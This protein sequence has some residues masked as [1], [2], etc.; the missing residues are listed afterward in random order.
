MTRKR[1]LRLMILH[2][3]QRRLRDA[4]TFMPASIL[5][6][7][8]GE[9]PENN[10]SG[11]PRRPQLRKTMR[12]LVKSYGDISTVTRSPGKI[13]IKFIL[14]LPETCAKTVCPLANST[15]NCVLGKASLT[16][17]SSQ[18]G[19]SFAIRQSKHNATKQFPHTA[20]E[21]A[22]GK[23]NSLQQFLN[24][25]TAIPNFSAQNTWRLNFL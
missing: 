20:C 17:A 23:P 7:R 11:F 18:M 3:S 10:L 12:P 2:F 5:N 21:H 9:R 24:M 13:L 6:A 16:V 4:L 19:S 25:S 22:T 8:Q 1:P 14:I 15:L